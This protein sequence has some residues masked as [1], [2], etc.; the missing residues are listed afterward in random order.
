MAIT[1]TTAGNALGQ[2]CVRYSDKINTTLR[3]GLEFEADLPKVSADYAYQGLDVTHS[4]VL[5]PYQKAHTPNNSET[6]NGINNILQVGKIDLTYDWTEMN[7][8][9]DK[10]KCNWWEAGKD[11]Q[12][13]TFPRY[14]MEKV[15]MPKFIDDLNAASWSGIYA[16]PTPGTPGAA[17]T[18]FTGYGKRITDAITATAITPIV[19]GA[20]VS[21]TMVAQITAF[22]AA[23]PIRYRYVEGVIEMSKTNAQ[24]Y[25]S[26]W[27]AK[28]P[29]REV[30]EK[31]HDKQYLRVDHFNKRIIGRTS[32][33]G[34]SRIVLRFPALDSMIVVTKNGLPTMPQFRFLE[35]GRELWVQTELFR[36]FGFE[37]YQHMFVND[38]V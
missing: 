10:W 13:W 30:V 32:M 15:V 5:Q 11:T 14:M 17:A 26:D 21:T 3:Q 7:K 24:L 25:A 27:A 20:F 29:G 12:E 2:Y 18:A 6:F 38:Q 34:S 9:Y 22:C 16:A 28:F 35:Q 36:C 31:E 8:F 23:L 37:T 33:E 1:I 19:T 4:D